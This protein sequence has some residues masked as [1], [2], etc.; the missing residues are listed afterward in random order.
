MIVLDN[1]SNGHQEIVEEVLQVKL[2]VGDM[3]DCPLLDNIFS[4]HNIA[5]VI[6]FEAYITVAES[7]T[8]PAKYHRNNVVGTLTVYRGNI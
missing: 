4:T 8:D 5:A 1:L 6:H 3:S 2:I 7:V